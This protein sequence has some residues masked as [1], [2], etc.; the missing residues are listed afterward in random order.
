MKKATIII[1]MIALGFGQ[2]QAWDDWVGIYADADGLDNEIEV[3]PGTEVQA[4][5]VM[6]VPSYMDAGV[7]AVDFMVLNWPE[8][9]DSGF[10][11]LDWVTKLVI[12]SIGE[13][14]ALAKVGGP[15]YPDA[16]GN[17]LLGTATFFTIDDT[18]PGMNVILQFVGYNGQGNPTIA[19]NNELW[20]I[21][22]DYA[23]LNKF[24]TAVESSTI[25]QIKALY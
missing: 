25:S 14:I 12:G 7:G 1:A 20:E 10:V 8:S 2:A 21:G 24:M 3:L 15:W 18:W 17:V 19:S 9:G 13:G 5:V 11:T 4:Y 22:G 23:W 16:N 6:H